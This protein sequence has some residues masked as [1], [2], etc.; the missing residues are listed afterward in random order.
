MLGKTISLLGL[1]IG[2]MSGAGAQAIV[3]TP[4][5]FLISDFTVNRLNGQAGTFTYTYL[6][7]DLGPAQQIGSGSGTSTNNHST[8]QLIIPWNLCDVELRLT[9]LLPFFL[10]RFYCCE[11]V[12]RASWLWWYYI[13][14]TQPFGQQLGESELTE[15][16][17]PCSG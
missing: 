15:R 14:R 9:W 5:Q 6:W 1:A 2:F 11:V 12:R 4:Q 3:N 13:R 7:A 17:L 10:R 8:R 16:R